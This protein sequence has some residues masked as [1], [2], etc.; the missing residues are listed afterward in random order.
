MDAFQSLNIHLE[1]VKQ[2]MNINLAFILTYKGHLLVLVN[3]GIFKRNFYILKYPSFLTEIQNLA[4]KFLF[5]CESL[6]MLEI[7]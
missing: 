2:E 3:T 1:N 4:S 7:I 6:E 5:P